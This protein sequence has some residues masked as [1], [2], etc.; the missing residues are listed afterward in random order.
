[1]RDDGFKLCQGR[2]RLAIRKY[3]F[4]ERVTMQWHRLPKEVME[5]PFQEALKNCRGVALRVMVSGFCGDELMVGLGDL[6]ILFQP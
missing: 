2:F 5:S 1:M 3:F 6:S 4:S